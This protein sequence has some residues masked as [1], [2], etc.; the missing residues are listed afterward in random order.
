[1]VAGYTALT[2]IT[3][4]K[5]VI[6]FVYLADLRERKGQP[7]FTLQLA[8]STRYFKFHLFVARVHLMNMRALLVFTLTHHPS[9][10]LPSVQLFMSSNEIYFWFPG[11]SPSVAGGVA[12]PAKT[13]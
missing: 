8:G 13:V 1:M 9:L 5:G 2:E 4:W 10:V 11:T 3:C 7:S 12:F 6:S